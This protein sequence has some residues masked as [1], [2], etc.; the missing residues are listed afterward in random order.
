MVIELD[1]ISTV[2]GR[3]EMNHVYNGMSTAGWMNRYP[4]KK[5]TTTNKQTKTNQK[6][7][8]KSDTELTAG[9][10]RKKR[11]DSKHTRV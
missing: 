7:K 5:K 9:V 4:P 11:K 2:A 8:T 3:V 10:L 1:F 6:T